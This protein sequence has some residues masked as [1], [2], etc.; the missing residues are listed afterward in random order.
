MATVKKGILT[1]S[2]EWWVHLRRYNKRKFWK[3][4]RKAAKLQIEAER[5]GRET[6]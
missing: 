3:A 4:E 5:L 1:R 6:R 2:P